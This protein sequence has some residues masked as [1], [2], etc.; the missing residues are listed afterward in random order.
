VEQGFSPQSHREHRA[1]PHGIKVAKKKK[2]KKKKKK[3]R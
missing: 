3:E 2:K 1:S